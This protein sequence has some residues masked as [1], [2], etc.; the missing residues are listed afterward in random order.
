M[1]TDAA[2]SYDEIPYSSTPFYYTHPDNL[3]ALATLHGMGPAP[4]ERCRVLELGCGRGGNLIPMAQALPGSRFVGVDL[5]RG[6]IADGRSV[7]EALGLTN[8][9][10]LPLSI[11]E[12]G[13]DFGVFDYV[14]CHGVYSWVPAEVQDRIL[15]V[16]GR[17]LAP[18]GV[19]YVS[20]NTYPGWHTRAV[21]REMLCFHVRPLPD[22][23]LRLQAARAFLDFLDRAARDAPTAYGHLLREEIAAVRPQADSYLF[24]EHLEE[25]NS[26]L[27]FTQFVERAAARGLQYLEEAQPTPL[28]FLVPAEVQPVLRQL[29]PDVVAFEQYLDFLRGRTFRRT[30]LCHAGVP[31]KRPPD[32]DTL[33][34]FHVTTRLRPKQ[35]PNPNAPA[36]AAEE[37]ATAK[38]T[39]MS[40]N[41]PFL[42]AA[43]HK[44][45]D[46]WPGS[47]PFDALWA[48][49]RSRGGG[50]DDSR[51]LS[52]PLLQCFL[53]NL[54]ELHLRPPRFVLA[55]GERPAASPL[56]RLQ[57]AAGEPA[58]NLRHYSTE[59][60]E[61]DGLVLR[62]LDG[63][64]DRAALVEA[65]AAVVASGDLEI[66]QGDQPLRDAA[67]V[68]E[69]LAESL[70]ASLHR[71]AG[72]ALLVG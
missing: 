41:N 18:H 4:A 35:A 22:P 27:Y 62:H 42:R 57:A 49:A 3:A 56:A 47:V 12:V 28:P 23:H 54:V 31:L 17:N 51:L 55:V 46:A 15:T 21:L 50:S 9:R 11:L 68:R 34:R 71:L 26:P 43:L 59:L 36:D 20:Y 7:V 40:T 65:L 6:Q 48:A 19:A 33:R 5:S 66:E 16:C 69:V 25:V 2:T 72:S 61:F 8:I 63:S 53:S 37:F 38:G 24:H 52:G 32:P 58:T 10:L 13:E 60:S 67:K 39:S 14:I 70:E 29:A 45:Y 30:L 44:L 1:S 64:R